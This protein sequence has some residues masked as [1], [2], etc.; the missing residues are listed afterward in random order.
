MSDEAS[1]KRNWCFTLNLSPE[2]DW[3]EELRVIEQHPHIKGWVY[4]LEEA[5]E[6]GQLHLQGY[7]EY[8]RPIRFGPLHAASPH[9]HWE[10][11]Y[12]SRQAAIDYCTKNESRL[13]GPF[14][15]STDWLRETG[16]VVLQTR[17]GPDLSFVC[18]VYHA[19]RWQLQTIYCDEL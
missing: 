5:P 14:S 7:C 3:Q 8:S 18:T 1:R 2:Y 16:Q 9:V 11:R 6:T 17:I 15:S 10:P 12:A 19:P 4:Q 13:D